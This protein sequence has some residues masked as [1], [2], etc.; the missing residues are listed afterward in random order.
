VQSAPD[1]SEVPENLGKFR[2]DSVLGQGGSGVVYGARLG[3]RRIAL[4][5]L[6]PDQVPTG[7]ERKRFLDEAHNMQRIDH[8]SIVGVI[9]AGELD[10][11]RPYL[12]MER[13]EGENLGQRLQR[14]PIPRDAALSIFEQL[15][16]AVGAMHDAGLIHR[17]LKPENVMLVG[18]D[19]AVLL[20]F[21]IAKPTDAPPSTTTQVGMQR[22][23]PAYMA[24]ERFFGARAS[25]ASDIYEL[26][27]ILYVMVVGGMPWPDPMNA[28][29]RLE[30]VPPSKYDEGFPP[31]LE[32]AL[33]AALSADAED[34]PTSA[35]ALASSIREASWQGDTV[36]MRPGT[37][38]TEAQS[39]ED[40]RRTSPLARNIA[41]IIIPLV[42]VAAAIAITLWA[43]SRDDG[44]SDAARPPAGA[45]RAAA[46][47][48]TTR[49]STP[50]PR[51]VQAS[52]PVAIDAGVA[53][54]AAGAPATEAPDKPPAD[55]P[56]EFKATEGTMSGALCTSMTKNVKTWEALPAQALAGQE[57]W[58]ADNYPKLAAAVVERMRMYEKLATEPAA[59][60]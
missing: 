27:V 33:M 9:D 43:T 55:V 19:R 34:R 51:T 23:T 32:S 7:R 8:P 18:D 6:R 44:D 59:A 15:S 56:A 21:G 5:V 54:D 25:L 40:M 58:C 41:F 36:P 12:A 16:A 2:I 28:K 45:K 26:G 35:A 24:P 60:P 37:R 53:V 42:G 11:G 22:G 57:K 47:P 17:D 4:K 29:A 31:G 39:T 48:E 38:A 14:G 3:E 52:S 30:P 1:T 46:K 49:K 20:D 10:D 13:L 50:P